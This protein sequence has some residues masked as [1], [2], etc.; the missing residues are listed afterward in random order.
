MVG[1]WE[2]GTQSAPLPMPSKPLPCRCEQGTASVYGLVRTSAT[3]LD[4]LGH[5]F[6]STIMI[7]FVVVR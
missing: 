7:V 1:S 2:A 4:F 3:P 6:P 5:G